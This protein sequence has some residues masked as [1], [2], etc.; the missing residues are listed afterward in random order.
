MPSATRVGSSAEPP[1]EISGSGMPVIGSSPVTAPMLTSA[2]V[3][4]QAMTPP[5]ASRA[6]G[7]SERRATRRPA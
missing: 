3:S 5:A 7:S 1:K 6:N 4:T 2:W